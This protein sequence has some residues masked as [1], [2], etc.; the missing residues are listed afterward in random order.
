MSLVHF[1]ILNFTYIQLISF[2]VKYLFCL[3]NA[4]ISKNK[5]KFVPAFKAIQACH[6]EELTSAS[7][8]VFA[9]GY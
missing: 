5:I 3:R 6:K 2:L 9:I 4:F 8:A 1:T 7:F